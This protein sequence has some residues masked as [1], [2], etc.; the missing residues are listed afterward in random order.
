M[1]KSI[2]KVLITIL[3][4][5]ALLPASLTADTSD[6]W[7]FGASIYGWFPDMSGTTNIP[8]GDG[9]FELSIGDILD[10]LEFTFQGSFDARKGNWGF[11]S[12]VIY[13]DV[14]KTE[15]DVRN[16]TVGNTQLPWEIN[17]ELGIG[18]KSLIWT[19]VGYYRLVED[20]NKSFD[21]LAGVRYADVDQDVSWS[22]SGDIG[23][24]P[25][26]GR[27]GSVSVGDTLWDYIVGFRGR[28]AF[29]AE[30]KWFIPYYA[31]IGTG[32]ADLTY[33]LAGGI[34]YKFSW[35]EIAAVY[36]YL[37]YDVASGNPIDTMDFG[38]PAVGAVFRW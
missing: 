13:M 35:G 28:L 2:N 30:N 14:A 3:A 20:S 17:G 36:R 32:D 22:L 7:E 37:E 33:Q 38:G 1:K 23:Q 21:L 25:L 6:S 34:G 16:G 24:T 19:N 29:G 9:D 31:D 10:N 8:V 15:K 11:F 27:E 18:M 4:S 5:A 12:D 26:P